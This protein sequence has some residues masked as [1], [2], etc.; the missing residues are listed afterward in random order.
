LPRTRPAKLRR[1]PRTNNWPDFWR[2]KDLYRQFLHLRVA[3]LTTFGTADKFPQA[4]KLFPFG[5]RAFRAWAGLFAV[6]AFSHDR[7]LSP[8]E[9]KVI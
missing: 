6:S 8:A 4:Y 5:L 3:E 9:T 7:R 2:D 1:Q